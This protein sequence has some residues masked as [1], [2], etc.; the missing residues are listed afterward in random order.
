MLIIFRNVDLWTMLNL[1]NFWM[2]LRQSFLDFSI[3][4]LC[5][6]PQ[7][8]LLQLSF[9][10]WEEE[11]W[12]LLTLEAVILRIMIYFFLFK[13]DATILNRR[14]SSPMQEEKAKV[15]QTVLFVAG[16]NTLLQS[17]FGTRLPAVIGA[18]YTFV[19]PTISI[20]LSGRW[21]DPDPESVSVFRCLFCTLLFK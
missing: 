14:L 13:S 17:Y 21:S 7:L 12:A 3:I 8:S 10:R 2:Q 1:S 4:W 16:L 19:A 9:P 18:S 15:I 5:S 20:I 6:V 11:M